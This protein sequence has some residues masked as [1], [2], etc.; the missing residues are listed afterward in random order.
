MTVVVL[1]A[2]AALA[3]AAGLG[4]PALTL[5]VLLGSVLL[6]PA[7]MVLPYSPTAALTSLR[8]VELGAVVGVIRAGRA[9]ARGVPHVLVPL[10]A[11]GV[12]ACITGIALA[13]PR[14]DPVQ[15]SYAWLTVLDE[16][17][18]ALVAL[19]LV[20]FLRTPDVVAILALGAALC[21]GVG[22]FEW[23]T[24]TSW[25]R[26]VLQAGH[27]GQNDVAAMVLEHRDGHVR[28]RGATEFALAYGWLMA[29]LLP[30]AAVAWLAV[31]GWF[32]VP[33]RI[34]LAGIGPAVLLA[35]YLSRGRSPL[36]AALAVAVILLAL[37]APRRTPYM[38]L[39]AV[40]LAGGVYWVGPDLLHKL[41]P[42]VDQGSVDTRVHRLPHVLELA[43]ARPFQG[44][45]FT[46]V[47]LF[48]PGFVDSSYLQIYVEAGAVAVTLFLIALAAPV[49]GVARGVWRGLED[50]D[51]LL[52]LA[53][54][55]GMVTLGVGAVFFDAFTTLSTCLTFWLLAGTGLVAAERRAGPL[56]RPR[57][58]EALTP[59]RLLVVAVA[60]GVGFGV[61]ALAPTHATGSAVYAAVNLKTQVISD[62]AGVERILVT[63]TC[64]AARDG[65]A[66]G[67]RWRL[68]QCEELNTPGWLRL[69]VTA[70]DMEEAG[71]GL[72]S[73][74]D[75]F[76]T[77]PHLFGLREQRGIAIVEGIPTAARVA[78]L[79]LGLVAG[80]VVLMLPGRRRDRPSP[81]DRPHNQT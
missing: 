35:V 47:Q 68:S 74:S 31:R 18:V 33:V 63:T 27:P 70:P 9:P 58:L 26:T 79:A 1:L 19:L 57:L 73:L 16:V 44:T 30:V 56:R 42:S 60:V 2:V 4:R 77:F 43:A 76:R 23:A 38:V 6:L 32:G 8:L 61:R 41:S 13:D 5:S 52:A 11:F 78:P 50:S 7:T 40:L 54:G 22:L 45:G 34:V 72:A 12:A 14:V 80:A 64:Q 36:A 75:G 37:L 48:G 24:G 55:L 29:A 15:A 66:V 39:L 46:G 3:V 67:Q 25:A 51:A 10:L 17:V 62:P 69:E 65:I 21:A 53:C 81:E 71:E 20:R 28:V 49:L 59:A